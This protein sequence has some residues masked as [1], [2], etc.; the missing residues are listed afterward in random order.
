ML[1]VEIA[2]SGVHVLVVSR[3]DTLKVLS[4]S[5]VVTLS[6]RHSAFDFFFAKSFVRSSAIRNKR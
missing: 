5:R 1:G 4:Q 2:E 6:R 3:F